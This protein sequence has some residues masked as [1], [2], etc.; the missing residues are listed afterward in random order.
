MMRTSSLPFFCS[1]SP[2]API[3]IRRLVLGF[4]GGL[5]D[6]IVQLAAAFQHRL[7]EPA[8]RL[9]GDRI[10]ERQPLQLVEI[11]V[12]DIGVGVGHVDAGRHVSECVGGAAGT[13]ERR[14]QC[15]DFRQIRHELSL[16]R[17]Y[18]FG[19]FTDRSVIRRCRAPRH[20]GHNIYDPQALFDSRE[21]GT[22][23]RWLQSCWAPCTWLPQASIPSRPNPP[24][25]TRMVSAAVSSR[26]IARPVAY[27]NV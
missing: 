23:V 4:A 24:P 16:Y 26:S 13:A 12:G 27:S 11:R 18:R 14:F 25:A 15:F 17:S 1:A 21:A 8:E 6:G 10:G 19:I 5:G 22:M 7:D 20:T 3:A 2:A 9:R